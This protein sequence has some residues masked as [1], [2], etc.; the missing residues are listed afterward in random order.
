[1]IQTLDSALTHRIDCTSMACGMGWS[2]VWISL[3][4]GGV[5]NSGFGCLVYSDM[6]LYCSLIYFLT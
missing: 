5:Y 1:M 6:Y 2:H 4:Y 3:R